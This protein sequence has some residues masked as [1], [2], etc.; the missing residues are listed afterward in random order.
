MKNHPSDLRSHGSL[1]KFAL[2]GKEGTLPQF[3][4]KVKK[5]RPRELQ[6]SQSHFYDQQ[7]NGADPPRNYAKANIVLLVQIVP[8]KFGSLL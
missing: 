8:Y 3:F 2:T 5:R 6:A 7:D 1:V 4:K